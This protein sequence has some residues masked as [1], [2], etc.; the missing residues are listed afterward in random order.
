MKNATTG[1]G[2][3]TIAQPV[4]GDDI[5]PRGLVQTMAILLSLAT[6]LTGV[7]YTLGSLITSETAAPIRSGFDRPLLE[8]FE[9]LRSSSLT[10]VVRVIT[11][12]GGT[13]VILL[14]L[15]GGAI[16]SYVLSKNPRWPIFFA[17]VLITSPQLSSLSKQLVDRPRP[18]LS[19]LYEYVL[20]TPA[21]PSGHSTN[22]AATYFALGLF[23]VTLTGKV[24][25]VWMVVAIVVLAVGLSRIYLGVHW[26]TDVLGGWLLGAASVG[27]C[28]LAVRPPFARGKPPLEA[29]ILRT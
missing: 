28:A 8:W 20:V 7:M 16:C 18:T 10:D 1:P 21:F 13:P 29:G 12:L 19:P 3:T 2:P 9:G 26:P 5:G 14:L 22:A 6:A 17:A 24:V 23:L 27:A 11:D 4:A 25:R 15:V